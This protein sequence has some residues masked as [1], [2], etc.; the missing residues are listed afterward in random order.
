MPIMMKWFAIGFATRACLALIVTLL[1]IQ[2]FEAVMLYLADFPTMLLLTLSEQFF[3]NRL[4]V[5]LTEG[6]PYYIPMNLIGCLLWGGI[7]M[8]IPV[9]YNTVSRLRNKSLTS[10]MGAEH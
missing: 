5:A 1:Q 7:F 9:A 10:G 4:F 2:N 6:H 8:L 3:P